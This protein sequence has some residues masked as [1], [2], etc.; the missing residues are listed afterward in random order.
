MRSALCSMLLNALLYALCAMPL[1]SSSMVH[2]DVSDILSRFQ[3]YATVDETYDTNIDLTPTNERDDFITTISPGFRFS[4]LPRSEVT[5]GQQAPTAEQKFGIDLDFNAGFVFY[6]DQD[7]DNYTSLNGLLNA[8]YLFSPKFS[9]RVR[10]YLIRSDD[11]READYSATAIQGQSLISRTTRRT[12]YYRN[13]VEPSVE[14]RFGRE[15]TVALNYRN[16]IYEIDSE[17]SEDSMENYINPRLAYWFNIHN[18]VSLEYGLTLGD[19]ERSSDLTGHMGTGRYTYRFNPRTSV[20]GEYTYF[21]RDFDPPSIDYEIHRPSVGIEHAFSPTL[22]GRVQ[23]G[24]YWADPE[25][26]ETTGDIYFDVNMSQRAKR[27]TYTIALQ[28][29]FTEDFFTADNLG[30]T[31]YYRAIGRVSHQLLERM[32][33]GLFGSY[34]WIK[35]YRG[36]GVTL[37]SGQKDNIWTIGG[38]AGY[39]LFRWLTLSLEGSFRENQSNFDTA[40]YTEYRGIFRITASF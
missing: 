18:G 37:A 3:L 17:I 33:V 39:Q 23:L 28:G 6:A 26:G 20:F 35:Y 14:Y 8:W 15:N 9:F 34:E 7:D 11:I 27:T 38:D 19:F 32:N 21:L 10:D 13:V 31:K 2:A 22:N 30:F 36:R 5:R 25:R 4:T 1:W 24:Y 12:P 29:G 16:N 40:D